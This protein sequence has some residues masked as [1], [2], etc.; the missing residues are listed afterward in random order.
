MDSP[1]KLIELLKQRDERTIN[2]V[3]QEYR[4][5]FILFAKRY[6]LDEDSVLDVYQDA[7]IALCENAEKGRMDNLESSLKTYL[8]S[9]GKYMIFAHLRKANKKVD[10]E[11][12]ENF[13]FEWEEYEEEKNSQEIEQIRASFSALGTKC[14]EILNM[15]YYQERN[16]DE[17]TELM[18]YENKN[19]AKS[20]K[21]RCIKQLRNLIKSNRNGK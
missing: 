9:I 2:Q 14:Q 7:I 4:S 1:R 12:I 21:S 17:I 3:Y 5:G 11:N 10:F 15:F 19:V 18:E 6:N 13:H 16:L 20:Q 8:F